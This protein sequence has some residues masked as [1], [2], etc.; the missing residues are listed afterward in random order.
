MDTH[1][2]CV[3]RVAMAPQQGQPR[4]PVMGKALRRA[5][6]DKPGKRARKRES[7]R[8]RRLNDLTSTGFCSHFCSALCAH[9]SWGEIASQWT[10]SAALHAG[11]GGGHM[12]PSHWS[13]AKTSLGISKAVNTSLWRRGL[14]LN[15]VMSYHM[16]KANLHVQVSIHHSKDYCCH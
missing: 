16:F 14:L 4:V 13:S 8:T 15:T 9:P 7:E 5:C 6:P 11:K 2:V 3:C 12:L 10:R 1:N